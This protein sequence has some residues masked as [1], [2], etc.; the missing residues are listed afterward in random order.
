MHSVR[1][2]LYSSLMEAFDYMI[3]HSQATRMDRIAQGGLTALGAIVLYI[4][5]RQFYGSIDEIGGIIAF[6]LCTAAAYLSL[7]LARFGIV[8]L[9]RY[10]KD[11]AHMRREALVAILLNDASALKASLRRAHSNNGGSNAEREQL[12]D[13]LRRWNRMLESVTGSDRRLGLAYSKENRPGQYVGSS[14]F[15][16]DEAQII[17]RKS[18]Q[19]RKAF[20][21]LAS[22]SSSSSSS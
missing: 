17:A 14:T 15:G 19:L 8:F 20:N 12:S 18:E 2:C 22:S 10:L 21:S 5:V 4:Q 6:S 16:F 9:R 1:R 7:G 3:Q 13:A 11:R